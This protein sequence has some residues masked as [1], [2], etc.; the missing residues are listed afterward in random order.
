LELGVCANTSAFF[1]A[2]IAPS[3]LWFYGVFG[4]LGMAIGARIVSGVMISMEFSPAAQRPTYIGISNTVAGIG[5]GLAPLLGGW[6]ANYSYNWLF[7]LSSAV[8]LSSFILLHWFVREP[9]HE[10]I[11]R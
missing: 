2:W 1:L 3:P 9:R 4:L 7:F 5:G 6:F 10:K 11:N 8:G